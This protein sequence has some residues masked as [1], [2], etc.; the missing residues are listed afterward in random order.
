M[1]RIVNI[2]Q[3]KFSVDVKKTEQYYNEYKIEDTQ[4]NRNFAKYCADMPEAERDF[5]DTF[6]I[7]PVCTEINHIGV[8]KKNQFPCGG[9]YLFYGECLEKPKS[10][11]IDLEAEDDI[12]YDVED[13]GEIYPEIGNF[14]IQFELPEGYFSEDEIPEGCVRIEVWAE[15]MMWLL[16]E[17]CEEKMYEPPKFWEIGRRISEFIQERKDD[18]EDLEET[19]R[20]YESIFTECKADF[21]LLSK[22]EYKRY[23]KQWVEQYAPSEKIKKEYLRSSNFMAFLW[24]MFSFEFLDCIKGENADELFNQADKTECVII[25]NIDYI[26]YKL[27][28]AGGLTDEKVEGFIDVTV[29]AADFSWTYSKTHELDMGPYFYKK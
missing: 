11:E 18:K 12:E 22:K 6:S 3:W 27:K 17:E 10:L 23:K 14:S 2:G 5:F 8:N 28:N 4:A 24:H 25:S 21:E 15:N 20:N 19:K 29:T 16:N 13:D 1:N 26:A 7:N 9:D